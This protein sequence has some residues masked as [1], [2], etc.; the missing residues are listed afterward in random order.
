VTGGAESPRNPLELR[1]CSAT[2]SCLFW[3]PWRQPLRF[4]WRLLLQR[5]GQTVRL[6]PKRHRKTEAPALSQHGRLTRLCRWQGVS[7]HHKCHVAR[8]PRCVSLRM[9][10]E[11]LTDAGRRE[12]RDLEG[13]WKNVCVLGGSKGVGREVISELSGRGVNVRL[14]CTLT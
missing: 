12:L 4:L 3:R 1:P 6:L 7:S 9:A 5:C 2:G 8:A 13:Q 11:D 14:K 10:D